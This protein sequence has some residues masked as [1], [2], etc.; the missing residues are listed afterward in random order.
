VRLLVTRPQPQAGE[1]VARLRAAGVEA[2]A[3]PLIRIGPPADAA[4]V[5][6][7][8]AAL[9]GCALAMFVSP[10]AVTRFLEHGGGMPWPAAV[11]AGATGP[12]TSGALRACGVPEACIVEPDGRE[13]AFDS[14]ALWKRLA[15]RRAWQGAQVLVVRGEGGRDW[16]AQALRE[17]GAEVHFV[18]AYRRL[19][20]QPD[21]AEAAL[22]QQ[23]LAAPAQHVWWLSSSEAVAHLVALVPQAD[24]HAACAI[25]SHARIA[26]RARAAG[27]GRVLEAG[28]VLAEMLRAL[29][30]I[31][32]P[33]P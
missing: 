33:A 10:N 2:Q 31:Q 25:A 16:L 12:G 23:A 3:L 1:W 9:P 24:W 22:L 26:E 7:A 28:P 21:A 5:R 6:S 30:S 29:A 20:P 14:E 8:W 13:G 15:P 19:P 32:S 11:W 4:A 18:E 27:F 17:Q